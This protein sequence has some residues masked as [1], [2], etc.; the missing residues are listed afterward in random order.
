[1]NSDRL[2]CE[3]VRRGGEGRVRLLA[4]MDF[5]EDCVRVLYPIVLRF[6]DVSSG[7]VVQEKHTSRLKG[8]TKS[9]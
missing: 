7:C 8:S 3:S 5:R 4:M 9:V 6:T 2:G 1:M